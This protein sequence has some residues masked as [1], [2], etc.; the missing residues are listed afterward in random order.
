MVGLHVVSH[1]IVWLAA[2][3]CS[4]EVGLPLFA[5]TTVCSIHYRNLLIFDKIGII[6]HALRHYILTLKQIDV[7]IVN[8]D[9]LNG[10]T[11]HIHIFYLFVSISFRHASNSRFFSSANA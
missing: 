1:Q 9:V 6:T 5:F 7:K 8:T 4:L 3:E 10:I 2:I 11:N